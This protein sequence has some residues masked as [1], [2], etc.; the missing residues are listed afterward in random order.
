METSLA[1][2]QRN[3]LYTGTMWV[4]SSIEHA[5]QRIESVANYAFVSLR[6]LAMMLR[7][8]VIGR[9]YIPLRGAVITARVVVVAPFNYFS[10]FVQ[11]NIETEVLAPVPSEDWRLEGYVEGSVMEYLSFGVFSQYSMAGQGLSF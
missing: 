2:L 8:F 5:T 6:D 1:L 11:L 4:V 7:A 3:R 10:R 9:G